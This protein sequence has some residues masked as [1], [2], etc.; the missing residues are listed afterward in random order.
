MKEQINGWLVRDSWGSL[1][2][3]EQKYI[4]VIYLMQI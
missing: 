1:T 2:F 3:Y 4:H